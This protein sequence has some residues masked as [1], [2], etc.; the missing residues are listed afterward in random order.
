M[1]D[2]VGLSGAQV[3]RTLA[4]LRAFGEIMNVA[5]PQLEDILDRAKL[6]MELKPSTPGPP[7][8]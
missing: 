2:P 4:E 1:P 7:T 5:P 6:A 8:P 3:I